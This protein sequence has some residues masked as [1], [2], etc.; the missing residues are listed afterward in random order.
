LIPC[1]AQRA[2]FLFLC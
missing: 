1:L 2:I